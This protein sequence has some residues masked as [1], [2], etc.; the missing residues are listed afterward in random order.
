MARSSLLLLT[1]AAFSAATGQLLFK[2]GAEGRDHWS[3]FL[4][5]PILAGLAFYGA[6]TL[7]WIYALS[8][9]KLVHVYAFTALTFVLVYLGGVLLLAEKLTASATAG[10]ILVVAGLYFISA[11]QA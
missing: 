10:V 11:H 7:L 2:I 9:E 1:L 8:Y 4:N 6:G 3:Q 5:L